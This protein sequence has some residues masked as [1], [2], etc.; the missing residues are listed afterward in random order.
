MK[1]YELALGSVWV[2]IGGQVAKQAERHGAVRGMALAGE[3]EGAVQR[4][5]EPCGALS[6]RGVAQQIEK[7]RR[8]R[9]RAHRVR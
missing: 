9:H 6:F 4:R 8:R 2:Q 5:H 1:R 7:P 3:G